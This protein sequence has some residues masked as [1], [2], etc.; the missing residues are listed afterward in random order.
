MTC[1]EDLCCQRQE[2]LI[3]VGATHLTHFLTHLW[4]QCMLLN[5]NMY[6]LYELNDSTW[7]R[8]ELTPLFLKHFV[9]NQLSREFRLFD[10]SGKLLK[11]RDRKWTKH[12]QV[13]SVYIV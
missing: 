10:Y 8:K 9:M 2:R 5:A 3:L 6:P 11:P 4:P 7:P 13:S 12:C 1:T